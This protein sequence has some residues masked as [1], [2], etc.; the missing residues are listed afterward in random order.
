MNELLP[1]LWELH[2]K[3][4]IMIHHLLNVNM[5]VCIVVVILSLSFVVNMTETRDQQS[6]WGSSTSGLGRIDVIVG[7]FKHKIPIY[8]KTLW[9]DCSEPSP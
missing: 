7:R 3:C 2:I 8:Q 4:S 1:R 5:C 6:F 9:T